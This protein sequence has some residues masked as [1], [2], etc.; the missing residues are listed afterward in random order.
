MS[1]GDVVSW[2]LMI[3]GY[4]RRGEL[5]KA[6]ELF[7]RMKNRNV[8]TWNSIIVGFIQGGWPKEALDFFHEMQMVRDKMVRPD[9]ITIASVLSACAYLGAIDHGKWVHGYLGRSGL[10]CDVVIGMAL[11]D[12]YGKC[13]CV[14]KAYETAVISVFALHGFCKEAFDLFEEM[15][16][17]GVK[18]NHVTFV[19]LL[20][21][22]AHSGLVEKGRWCFDMMRC[23]YSIEP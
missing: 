1:N 19:G 6:L 7:R 20:S 9:K 10:E 15:E 11:V 21:A 22:C 13:G 16:M 14:E 8:I 18:P 12:M 2:N 4:L 5:D 23:A 17:L 3:I